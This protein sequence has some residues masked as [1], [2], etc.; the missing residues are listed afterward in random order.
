MRVGCARVARLGVA[1]GANRTKGKTQHLHTSWIVTQFV[2]A[3]PSPLDAPPPRAVSAPA[4][5]SALA[6]ALAV[7]GPRGLGWS[8][9]GRNLGGVRSLKMLLRVLRNVILHSLRAAR[10]VFVITTSITHSSLGS[11]AGGKASC[12]MVTPPLLCSALARWSVTRFVADSRLV[13]SSVQTMTCGPSA[14][15]QHA[16]SRR[17]TWSACG[18]HVASTRLA[19][20]QHTVGTRPRGSD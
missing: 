9:A 12:V 1:A 19:C 6:P 5:A 4:S 16:V 15:G 13:L 17:S 11:T 18:Q 20:G 7:A 8:R 10:L 14:C 3:P 2:P